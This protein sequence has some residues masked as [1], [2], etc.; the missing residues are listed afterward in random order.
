LVKESLRVVPPILRRL[1][2]AD[3]AR[4]WN[5]SEGR[6]QSRAGQRLQRGLL[7]WV[8]INHTPRRT[9]EDHDDTVATGLPPGDAGVAIHVQ[10]VHT[11]SFRSSPRWWNGLAKH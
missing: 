5:Q 1:H 3:L 10:H 6:H 11:L 9:E 4:A 8:E 7:V 2:V